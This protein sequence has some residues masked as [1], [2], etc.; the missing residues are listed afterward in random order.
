MAVEWIRFSLRGHGGPEPTGTQFFD[1]IG[2]TPATGFEAHPSNSAWQSAVIYLFAIS[3]EECQPGTES[4]EKFE[5]RITA[6]LKRVAEWLDSLSPTAFDAWRTRGKKADLFI[7]GWMNSDQFDLTLLP[8][9]LLACGR[10]GL[11]ITIC[12][13]D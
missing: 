13:N 6:G 8:E 5:A 11:P 12:T 3:I 1:L 4:Y 10:L 7:G 9:F 2:W